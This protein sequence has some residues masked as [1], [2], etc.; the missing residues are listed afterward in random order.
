MRQAHP[1]LTTQLCICSFYQI[2]ENSMFE[3]LRSPEELRHLAAAHG[4]AA[5]LH[6]TDR[7]MPTVDSAA[8]ALGIP[9]AAMTKN[10]IFLAAEQ[11]ILAIAAGQSRINDRTLARH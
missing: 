4:V 1:R 2:E 6:P 11:P 10:I 5:T 3:S 7:P 9:V 8:A